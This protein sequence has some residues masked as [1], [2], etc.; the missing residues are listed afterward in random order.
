MKYYCHRHV[1]ENQM[2]NLHLNNCFFFSFSNVSFLFAMENSLQCFIYYACIENESFLFSFLLQIEKISNN[3]DI[4][5][6]LNFMESYKLVNLPDSLYYVPN[7]ITTEEEEYLLSCVNN[8]PR[9]R[10]VQ[11]RNRRLQNW[12]GQPHAKGMIQTESLPNWLQTFNQRIL[13]LGNGTIY[14]SNT[15]QFNHCLV[16]EY[17][18]GQ[19]IMP[20]T[21]G[22][23]YHPIVTT[24]SLQSHT[25][26]EFYR[27]V[28]SNNEEVRKVAS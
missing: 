7:F 16:N 2:T 1:H 8:V 26:I 18:A 25:V 24:I 23:V 27:P 10:W 4:S 21:D 20:H 19:G 6:F 13:Q 28:D 17:E 15:F 12:G 14:P 9:T 3:C 11:L 5:S 22:P